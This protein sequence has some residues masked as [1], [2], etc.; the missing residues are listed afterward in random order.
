VTANIQKTC[1]DCMLLIYHQLR[2]F[3]LQV[4]MKLMWLIHPMFNSHCFVFLLISMS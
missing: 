4:N 3:S 2:C 1:Q